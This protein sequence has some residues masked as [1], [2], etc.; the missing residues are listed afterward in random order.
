V[1]FEGL[2]AVSE[3]VE[4]VLKIKAAL[5]LLLNNESYDREWFKP[6][7]WTNQIKRVLA[8][9]G[10]RRGYSVWA[11]GLND[12]DKGTGRMVN[13]EWLYDLVW[14]DYEGR[15]LDRKLRSIPL[16]A[17]SEMG[18]WSEVVDDFEKLIICNADVKVMLFHSNNP[19][20]A[21]TMCVDLQKRASDFSGLQTR[22]EYLLACLAWKS[23][24]FIFRQ[25]SS[26]E[27]T[28]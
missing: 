28:K 11:S 15:G 13:Q 24:S 27:R 25:F 7:D 26:P 18:S 5:T 10:F 2:E 6:S 12:L 16:V 9:I 23:G 14:I 4:A 20:S 19:S 3:S 21:E 22:S 8:E 17:E 1:A